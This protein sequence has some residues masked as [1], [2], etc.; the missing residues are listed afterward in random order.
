MKKIRIIIL[1]IIVALCFSCNIKSDKKTIPNVIVEK[2]NSQFVKDS[3]EGDKFLERIYNSIDEKRLEDYGHDSFRFHHVDA[4]GN[5]SIFRVNYFD[6]NDIE[7]VAK[8]YQAD[9]SSEIGKYTLTNESI[10]N[11]SSE[12]FIEFQNLVKGAYF[13]DLKM[14]EYPAQD[15][16]D[17]Y[18]YILEQFDYSHKPEKSRYHMV[19]RSV[20][21][22]G[23]FRQA[24]EKLVEF[25]NTEKNRN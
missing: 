23:S 10:T 13:W 4:F 21:Y 12:Q 24:C 7:L 19:A 1:S 25:Y 11:L 17:G 9:E 18:A 22:K 20:P 15:Y 8:F 5:N 16:F 6:E 2:L 14:I 3:I